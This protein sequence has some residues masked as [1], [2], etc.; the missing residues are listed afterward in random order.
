[1]PGRGDIAIFPDLSQ[2]AS[3]G[4]VTSHTPA[5][6]AV[7]LTDVDVEIE[8]RPRRRRPS[9][10][11]STDKARP[12]GPAG[13]GRRHCRPPLWGYQQATTLDPVVSGGWTV[14]PMGVAR[15]RNDRGGDNGGCATAITALGDPGSDG[16]GA[17][18]RRATSSGR[19][20]GGAADVGAG[21]TGRCPAS[22]GEDCRP[23]A[24]DLA[25]GGVRPV[26]RRGLDPDRCRSSALQ[27]AA[28]I[29]TRN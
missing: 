4:S 6:P 24:G 19:C 21:A 23:V 26:L 8:H 22:P 12:L 1:M 29:I 28:R 15:W 9:R 5:A 27:G 14:Y 11:P 18:C 10:S 16:S 13:P 20:V 17:G 25:D 2:A 3:V 7:D